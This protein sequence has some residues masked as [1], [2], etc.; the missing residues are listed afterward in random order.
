LRCRGFVK[1]GQLTILKS[2][3]KEEAAPSP[4]PEPEPEPEQPQPPMAA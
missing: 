3:P 4:A 2:M 1:T